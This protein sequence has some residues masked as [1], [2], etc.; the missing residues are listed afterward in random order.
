MTCGNIVYYP[1]EDTEII[2]YKNFDRSYPTHTHANHI[3]IGYVIEGCVH[4]VCDGQENL[5][6]AGDC[7]CIM[8]DI[9]HAME[10]VND[11]AYSMVSVCIAV[12][13]VPCESDNEISYSKRLKQI[14]LNTPENVFLIEDMAQ[15]IG[16]SPF[17]MI[18]QFKALCGLTPHQFQIQCRVRK[19]QKMLERGKSV[20]EAAYATGFCDQSHFDRCFR[21]IVRLTPSEYKQ[22]V[23]R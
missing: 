21:K 7:F 6:H 9:P 17:H 2:Y 22:S 10:P 23:K 12:D 19:A 3:T 15:S 5:Y 20:V 8:P 14:I 4:L 11:R 1:S 16:I 18:R 13:K